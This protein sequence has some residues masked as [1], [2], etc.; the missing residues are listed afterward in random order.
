M[1][2]GRAQDEA[3]FLSRFL[4]YWVNPLIEKGCIGRLQ[5][6]DDLFEL[7]ESLNILNITEKVQCVTEKTQS[8]LT[9]LRRV[10]GVEFFTIG[11]LRFI[12]DTSG[13]AGPLLLAALLKHETANEIDFDYLPYL[14]ALG[15]FGV[16]LISWFAL[17][18]IQMKTNLIKFKL[19]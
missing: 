8:L 1:V 14:Y 5:R 9:I 10:F 7:P 2:L 17:R 3:P 15:L 19:S 13:F 6:I 4:F 16:T 18:N 11:L 12:S